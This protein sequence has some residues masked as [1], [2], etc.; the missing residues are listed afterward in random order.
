MAGKKIGLA[1]GSGAVRGYALIPIIKRLEKEGI[2]ISAISG[3]SVG[4]IIGAYYALHGEIDTLFEHIKTMSRRDYLKLVDPNNPKISLLKGKKIKKFLSDH[5]FEDK[6]YKNL[7]IP[8]YICATDVVR[9]KPVYI[10]KGKLIDAV[11]A[12]IS[13]PGLVPPYQKGKKSF[14]DGGVLDPVPT[15]PL[16]GSGLRKVVGI[17]LMGFKSGAEKKQDE[18]LVSA[19]MNSFYMMMEQIAKKEDDHGLFILNPRFEPEPTRMLAFYDW[20]ENYQIG[21]KLI[22]KNIEDLKKWLQS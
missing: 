10:S 2:E 18:G 14:I 3:S 17:N 8:L 12:S 4:A 9:H 20:K 13:I 22:D 6:T 16:L 1:L 15:K 19:L 7:K 5:Y 11:M 21:K